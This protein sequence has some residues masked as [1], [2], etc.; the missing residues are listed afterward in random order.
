MG[1][2][3]GEAVL[4][5][6]YTGTGGRE[7]MATSDSH[8]AIKELKLKI[9]QRDPTRV[10]KNGRDILTVT[11]EDFCSIVHTSK[12]EFLLVGEGLGQG[13]SEGIGRQGGLVTVLKLG[14]DHLKQTKITNMK[15][16]TMQ[17]ESL[18]HNCPKV[19]NHFSILS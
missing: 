6:E 3:E 7:K 2:W 19:L 1:G 10:E 18:P 12:L 11:Y 8:N 9:N 16:N 5:I 13:L 14:K 17:T 15:L 4:H